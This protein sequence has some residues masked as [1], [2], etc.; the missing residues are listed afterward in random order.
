MKTSEKGIALIKQFEGFRPTAYL[1]PAGI[2]TIGYG[3]VIL[4]KE[5]FG[6]LTEAGATAILKKDLEIA[7]RAISQFILAPLTQNQFD[8]LASFTFNLGGGALQR[9]TLRRKLN[10]HDYEG[11]AREFLQW[12]NSGGVKLEGLV[13]RRKAERDLFEEA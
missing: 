11:A 9:S 4:P 8:A 1:C 3:H 5:K 6:T 2:P 7:E 10:A 12:V 13:R